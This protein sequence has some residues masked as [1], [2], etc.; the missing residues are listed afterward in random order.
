MAGFLTLQRMKNTQLKLKLVFFT[1]FLLISGLLHAQGYSEIDTAIKSYPKSFSSTAKLAARINEEFKS[2]EEKVRAIY[3]WIALNVRYDL[4]FYKAQINNPGIAYSYS[5]EADRVA[6]EQEFR[7]NLADKTLKTRKGV[8]QGYAALFHSLCDLTNIKVMDISGTSKN[9][10]SNIGKLPKIND[11]VWNVVKIGAS[12]KFI[13]VTWGSGA[14]SSQTGS[15]VPEF[16]GAY[17]FTSPELFFLNHFPEDKRML[18]VAKTEQDFADLPLY[19]GQYLKANYEIVRP[20]TG[21]FFTSKSKIIPFKIIDLPENESVFYVFSSDNKVSKVA[22]KRQGIVSEF[23]IPLTNR[24]K[25][26]L[27]L[28]IN[29]QSVVS[30]KI[31]R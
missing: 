26:Y 30:Y 14:L 3:T 4:K 22:I 9:H 31:Q 11:H 18:M 21:I 17:F 8:C 25:G 5:S 10:P 16:N 15:F 12:W 20:E 23:E 27:T 24:N 6:K 29:N 1:T 13:D 19:Y 7:Q 2:E 28:F